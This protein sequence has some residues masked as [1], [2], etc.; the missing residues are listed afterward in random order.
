[1]LMV[2]CSIH[3]KS[4]DLLLTRASPRDHYVEYENGLFHFDS[5]TIV[6]LCFNDFHN[7]HSPCRIE[8]LGCFAFARHAR[9]TWWISGM[10][11]DGMG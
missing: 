1:M 5:R 9:N 7:P 2:C 6:Y 10:G 8:I 3:S 11:W 4:Y